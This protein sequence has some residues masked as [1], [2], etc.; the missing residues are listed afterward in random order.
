M[1]MDMREAMNRITSRLG[2]A[3]VNARESVED[4][5]ARV[6]FEQGLDATVASVRWGVVEISCDAQNARLLRFDTDKVLSA[7]QAVS[8]DVRELRITVQVQRS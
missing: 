6:L 1:A 2:V 8:P 5:V 3:P 4:A 7:V